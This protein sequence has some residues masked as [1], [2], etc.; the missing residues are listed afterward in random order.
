MGA[1]PNEHGCYGRRARF[2]K[3]DLEG[4]ESDVDVAAPAALMTLMSGA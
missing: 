2:I 4:R 3:R 1:A